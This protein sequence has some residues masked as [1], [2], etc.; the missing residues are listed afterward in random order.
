MAHLTG[1]THPEAITAVD[2]TE[3]SGR[4][5]EIVNLAQVRERLLMA[6]FPVRD[7]A[8]PEEEVK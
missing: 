7:E 6:P 2:N 3:G 1:T 8:Y 5:A 4:L